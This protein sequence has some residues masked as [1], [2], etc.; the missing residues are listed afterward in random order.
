MHKRWLLTGVLLLLLD[1]VAITEPAYSHHPGILLT[2]FGTA[3]VDGLMII[4]EWDGA[5][6]IE[7][8]ANV[9]A[10]DGGG[11]TPATLYVMNDDT[12]LYLAVKITRSSL[13]VRR[14]PSLSLTT[15]TKA[16]EVSAMMCLART[17]AY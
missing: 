1:W 9:P 3:K 16:R 15:I 7:F 14:A 12:T 11:T 13:A 6:K 10:N 4:G 5:S 8:L 2:G 17:S